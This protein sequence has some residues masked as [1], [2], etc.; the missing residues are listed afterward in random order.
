MNYFKLQSRGDAANSLFS[1]FF[2]ILL[3]VFPVFVSVFYSMKRNYTRIENRDPDFQA[4]YGSIIHGL[5]FKRRGR[6]ALFYPCLSLFRKMWLA[7]MLVFQNDKPVMRIFCVMVQALIM[8]VVSGLAE[9]M[10]M[11]SDNR[12]Q[13]FNEFSVLI[14]CYH[15]LPLTDF[16]TDQEARNLVGK[17]LILVTQINLGVNIFLALA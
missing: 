2:G 7:Y 14:F 9:P 13:I 12:M 5:N 4:R 6:L 3:L 17:S 16:I 1:L 11:I 8:I 10:I 15:L